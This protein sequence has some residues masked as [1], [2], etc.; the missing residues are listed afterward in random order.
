MIKFVEGDMLINAYGAQAF[1]HGVNCAGVMGAGIAAQLKRYYPDMFGEY[2]AACLRGDLKLGDVQVWKN[3]NGFAILNL[4]TQSR[5]GA[6][7]E[8]LALHIALSSTRYLLDE[9]RIASLAMPRIGCGLGKLEW[10]VVR[11]LV[12]QMFEQWQGMVYVY[13]RYIA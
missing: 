12:Q 5:P 4:G 3:K 2:R 1:A 6:P 7:A 8:L 10:K 9:S 13:E 11:P